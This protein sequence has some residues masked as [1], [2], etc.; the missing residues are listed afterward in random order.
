MEELEQLERLSLVSKICTELENHLGINDKDLAEFIIMLGE[1]NE[2]LGK[3]KAALKQ[4]GAEFPDSFSANLLRLI[5]QMKP[6]SAAKSENNVDD[7]DAEVDEELSKKREKFRGL[8][9]PDEEAQLEEEEKAEDKD[10]AV[11]T[12][13][14]GELEALM[15]K[16]KEDESK[17]KSKKTERESSRSPRRHRRRSRSRSK[18][19][20]SRRSRS[21]SHERDRDRRRRRSRST[22]RRRGDDDRSS[23]KEKRSEGRYGGSSRVEKPLPDKPTVNQIY[24][25]RVTGIMQFGCFAQLE[26]LRG[27]NEGLVHISE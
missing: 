9:L 4:N 3:F 13:A 25:G 19:R 15:A 12:Q 2:T 27:R 23:R 8:C 11:V 24:D 7:D 18:E 26:G 20:R 14:M 10:E 21:R 5:Q 16:A 22:E 6:T 17:S 1:T